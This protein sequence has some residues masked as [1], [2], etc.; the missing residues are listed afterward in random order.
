MRKLLAVIKAYR[1]RRRQGSSV[2]ADRS[3]LRLLGYIYAS[4]T[5]A[6]MLAATAVVTRNANGGVY[7]L[8]QSAPIDSR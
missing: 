5:I 8:D 1:K 2:M 3:G 6:V 4:V 7:A